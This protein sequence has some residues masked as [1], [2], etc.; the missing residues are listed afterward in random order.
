M[1][2]INL[3]DVR[4]NLPM[5]LGGLFLVYLAA[6][7]ETLFNFILQ[8]TVTGRATVA[9]ATTIATSIPMFFAVGMIKKS[10]LAQWDTIY[11]Y[12]KLLDG[13]IFWLAI[14]VLMATIIYLSILS[15]GPNYF[16][17]IAGCIGLI[18][19]IAIYLKKKYKHVGP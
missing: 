11:Y 14:I 2:P 18:I 12:E 17:T 16:V 6:A 10:I 15:R 5:F 1:N 9:I 7:N 19:Y 13:E 3:E 4:K 8:S